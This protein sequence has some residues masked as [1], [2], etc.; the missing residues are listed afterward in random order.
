MKYLVGAILI[1]VGIALAI[2]IGVFVFFIGG[3]EDMVDGAKAN[4]TDGGRIA[5]GAAQVFIL[6]ELSAGL[7]LLICWG[8]AALFGFREPRRRNQYRGGK[9]ARQ[10]EVEWERR[11]RGL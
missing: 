4:P 8:L 7:V 5:W 11:V 10:V 3:I 1:L 2:Y 6:A 9:S